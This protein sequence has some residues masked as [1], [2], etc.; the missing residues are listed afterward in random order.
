MVSPSNHDMVSVTTGAGDWPKV[1]DVLKNGGLDVKEPG[2]KYVA[3]QTAAIDDKDSA[4]KLMGFM[5]AIE[6]DEDVSEVHTN[7][8]L[9]DTVASQLT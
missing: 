3:Q 7:A 1:R 2:L 5:E 4:E 6:E 8:D 9:D